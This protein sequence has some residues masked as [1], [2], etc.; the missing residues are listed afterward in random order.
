MVRRRRRDDPDSGREEKDE[1]EAIQKTKRI[2][3]EVGGDGEERN[4]WRK[5]WG[6]NDD[7]EGD[8]RRGRE[9]K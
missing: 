2:E 4:S 5:R 6:E 7:V 3:E 8:G 1:S 9:R